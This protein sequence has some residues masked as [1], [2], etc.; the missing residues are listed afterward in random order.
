MGKSETS[1]SV[2][3]TLRV[4]GFCLLIAGSGAALAA[5]SQ[6]RAD[7]SASVMVLADDGCCVI[8]GSPGH[9]MEMTWTRK[10]GIPSFG[11]TSST[12]PVYV[13]VT[14]TGG[15]RSHL[16][17]NMTLRTVAGAGM[18]ETTGDDYPS[19]R[20]NF[21]SKGGYWRVMPYLANA[22]FYTDEAALNR[23]TGNI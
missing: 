9:P 16:N 5:D 3:T 20:K 6:N 1:R 19:L 11:V 21:G 23:G 18:E 2:V 14:A 7:I 12:E 22:M 10:E 8:V 4:G 15:D 13:T 17:S